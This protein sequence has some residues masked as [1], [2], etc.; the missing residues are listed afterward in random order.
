MR[1]SDEGKKSMHIHHIHLA[2]DRDPNTKERDNETIQHFVRSC[3][4]LKRVDT[5]YIALHPI[6]FLIAR[7][8]SGVGTTSLEA[9]GI[10]LRTPT[11]GAP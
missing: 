8:Y 3:R 2:G 9:T 5:A 10:L 1:D 7:L 4:G 11:S 6:H